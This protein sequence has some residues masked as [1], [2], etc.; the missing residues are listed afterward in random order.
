M[1]QLELLEKKK[2]AIITAEYKKYMADIRYSYEDEC[3]IVD[4][5]NLPENEDARAH[6]NS[7]EEAVS[8]FVKII[9]LAIETGHIEDKN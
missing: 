2:T 4:F 7:I 6:G 9:D 5:T 3:W 1:K 8:K